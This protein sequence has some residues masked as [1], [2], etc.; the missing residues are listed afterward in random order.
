MARRKQ[1]RRD[2]AEPAIEGVQMP[3]WLA[4]IL[5]DTPDTGEPVILP[6]EPAKR[7]PKPLGLI[8]TS[9]QRQTLVHP[10]RLKRKIKERLKEAAEGT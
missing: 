9:K 5:L 7:K 6:V 2:V 8:L 4:N 3:G 1:T 10:T